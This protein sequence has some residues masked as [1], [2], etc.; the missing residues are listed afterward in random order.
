MQKKVF[1]KDLERYHEYKEGGNEVL[2]EQ[3]RQK[4]EKEEQI[5]KKLGEMIP[6]SRVSEEYYQKEAAFRE[7]HIESIGED[8]AKMVDYYKLGVAQYK[9]N[10]CQKASESFDK[11]L[12]SSLI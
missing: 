11:V 1:E 8:S 7:Q 12:S 9:S 3:F 4:V 10:Q 5:L 2:I 6:D